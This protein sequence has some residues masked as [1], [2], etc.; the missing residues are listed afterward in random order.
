MVVCQNLR[1]SI[2]STGEELSDA[3]EL[4]LVNGRSLSELD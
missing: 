2:V 3:S 4:G 1:I